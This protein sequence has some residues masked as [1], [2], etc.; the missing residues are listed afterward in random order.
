VPPTAAAVV[1][2]VQLWATLAGNLFALQRK[3]WANMAGFDHTRNP[4]DR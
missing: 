1:N 4:Q 3:T 2:P